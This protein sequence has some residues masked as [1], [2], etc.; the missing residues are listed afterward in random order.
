MKSLICHHLS[1]RKR[2]DT[3]LPATKT[4]PHDPWEQPIAEFLRG[5]ARAT[6]HDLAAL[7]LGA[8][9]RRAMAFGK[10]NPADARRIAVIMRS[11]GWERRKSKGVRYWTPALEPAETTLVAALDAHA[12]IDATKE[13]LRA[14]MPPEEARREL[15]I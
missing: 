1:P 6:P 11:L 8:V 14:G 15:A 7:T 10:A 4:R 12:K 3:T 13:R 2:K 5:R 9:G